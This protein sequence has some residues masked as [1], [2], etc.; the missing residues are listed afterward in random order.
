MEF[1]SEKSR[2]L[3]LRKGHIQ[4]QFRFRIKDH[5]PNGPRE[6]SLGKWY[7]ADLNDKQSVREMTIQVDTWMTSLEKSSLP[8]MGLP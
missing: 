6:T 1:K 2:S 7:R 5:H 8:G 3:V 4:D